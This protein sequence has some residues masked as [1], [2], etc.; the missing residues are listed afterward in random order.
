MIHLDTF[1]WK[2]DPHA[3][4]DGAVL[5]SSGITPVPPCYDTDVPEAVEMIVELLSRRTSDLGIVRPV[6][7][8]CDNEVTH[9]LQEQ[10]L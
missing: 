4:T 1:E 7:V 2:D 6:F 10:S 5:P 3:L 8:Q 9:P